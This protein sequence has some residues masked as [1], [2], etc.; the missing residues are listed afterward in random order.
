MREE[1]GRKLIDDMPT[2]TKRW[3]NEC[4]WARQDSISLS[5]E[6][7]DC[8]K[9][10]IANIHDTEAV[11]KH[12]FEVQEKMHEI[13]TKLILCRNINEPEEK[14]IVYRVGGKIVNGED[15]R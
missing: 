9:L 5:R 10:V 1:R 4:E 15:D 14:R 11:M 7:R 6:A 2:P 13:E 3:P 12:I 8:L